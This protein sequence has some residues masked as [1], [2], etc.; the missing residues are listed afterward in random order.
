MARRQLIKTAAI[1]CALI[2]SATAFCEEAERISAA[3]KTMNRMEVGAYGMIPIGGEHVADGEYQVKVESNSPY[4]RVTS[5][6]LRVES[7]EMELEFTIGSTSY[8]SIYPGTAKEARHA[9]T[10]M[11]EGTVSGDDTVFKMPVKA[12]ND[13]IACAAYSKRRKKWY[14][15]Q[16]LINAASLPESALDITLPDYQAI[17]A[18]IAGYGSIS[19]ETSEDREKPVIPEAVEVELEDGEYSIEVNMTGGSG[20]ASVS[21][22]TRMIVRDG[23][24]YAE[25]LWSSSHYDYMI[26]G[27]ERYE[28]VNTDGGSSLFEIPIIELDSPITVIAD[29]TAMGEPVEIEYTLVF[30]EET[31]GDT[32]LIP[33]VAAKRVLTISVIL[34]AVG[35]I[36]NHFLHKGKQ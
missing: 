23:R 20:R 33:Q 3:R 10:G 1:I 17:E 36:L 19:S 6:L 16:L 31:I 34:I 22:P 26:V 2:F 8:L 18:A 5:A 4:F 28:N 25:M 12:L 14:P 29:T 15:R 11:I 30:Y 35:A 24:A 9:E 7:G 27:G 21:S 32:S 13:P